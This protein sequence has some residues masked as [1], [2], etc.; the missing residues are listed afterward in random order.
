M[1]LLEAGKGADVLGIDASRADG[2]LLVAP[3]ALLLKVLDQLEEAMAIFQR[4]LSLLRQT[5]QGGELGLEVA[6][7]GLNHTRLVLVQFLVGQKTLDRLA[8]FPDCLG[9]CVHLKAPLQI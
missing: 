8:H 4:R 1:L 6:Q 2:K 5:E 3:L 7:L 9:H